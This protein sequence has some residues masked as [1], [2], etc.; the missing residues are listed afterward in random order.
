MT[1]GED[2]R[3]VKII[4][5]SPALVVTSPYTEWKGLDQSEFKN[6]DKRIISQEVKLHYSKLLKLKNRTLDDFSDLI[7]SLEK[8]RA[9]AEETAFPEKLVSDFRDSDKSE[10]K[11]PYTPIAT[12]FPT[13][14]HEAG[15]Q[16][17]LLHA[18][19]PPLNG[20]VNERSFSATMNEHG[21]WVTKM[22]VMAYGEPYIYLLEDDKL[23]IQS[24]DKKISDLIN[25]KS[26]EL[27]GSK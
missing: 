9:V 14:L 16:F 19:N 7:A 2:R 10:M 3:W 26:K 27:Q 23:G 11:I 17:G 4:V 12:L 25:E 13:L 20:G 21:K 5:D 6:D 15:H 24:I 22:A 18:D 1:L 8:F